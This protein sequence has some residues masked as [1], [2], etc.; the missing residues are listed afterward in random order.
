MGR[1]EMLASG[2]SL[3]AT[4]FEITDGMNWRWPTE[5]TRLLEMICA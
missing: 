5:N 4:E 1:D 2:I 3:Q